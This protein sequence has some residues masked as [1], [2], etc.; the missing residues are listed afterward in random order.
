[1]LTK[2]RTMLDFLEI[3]NFVVSSNS[4]KGKNLSII[5]DKEDVCHFKTS[6]NNCRFLAF[7][8]ADFCSV[9]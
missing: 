7:K 9:R 3:N 6:L 4:D 8:K 1:M 5:A 2:K